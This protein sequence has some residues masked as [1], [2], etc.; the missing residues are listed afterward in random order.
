[1]TIQV[2]RKWVAHLWHWGCFSRPLA[3]VL[4]PPQGYNGEDQFILWSEVRASVRVPL[5]LSWVSQNHQPSWSLRLALGVGRWELEDLAR[6]VGSHRGWRAGRCHQAE[7]GHVGS[8]HPGDMGS[9][10]RDSC[11]SDPGLLVFQE[12]LETQICR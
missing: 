11:P 2:G 5:S 3:H 8:G 10:S 7:A 4:T 9:V 12:N 1:M 6:P